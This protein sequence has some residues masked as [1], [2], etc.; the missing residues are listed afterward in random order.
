LGELLEATRPGT[1]LVETPGERELDILRRHVPEDMHPNVSAIWRYTVLPQKPLPGTTEDQWRSLRKARIEFAKACGLNICISPHQRLELLSEGVPEDQ[2]IV[3]PN[4]V[5]WGNSPAKRK[6][7]EAASLRA[8]YLDPDE[9]GVL[10]MSRVHPEKGLEW[11][12]GLI[13]TARAERKHLPPDAPYKKM[14]VT[15]TGP[16]G[17]REFWE[18]LK[19]DIAAA[20]ADTADEHAAD[21]I[22]FEHMEE[23][24]GNELDELYNAYDVLLAPSP[25]E[26]FPRVPVQATGSGMTIIGN[27]NCPSTAN[28]IVEAP[29]TIGQTAPTPEKAALQL[30]HLMN[31]ADQLAL[32]QQN[33][34][35]WAKG[36]YT[37]PRAIAGLIRALRLP[38]PRQA[39]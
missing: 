30:L 31:R 9:L 12:P 8:K 24:R 21:A 18:G 33:A 6:S 16:V 23:K 3:I 25:E 13:R 1:I 36:H 32:M 4:Q 2:I 5:G 28:I 15:L 26:G 22:T 17:D 37:Y 27:G 10:I 20:M 34:A 14:R 38:A 29:Y 7:P 19:A 11:L 39:R 35:Q